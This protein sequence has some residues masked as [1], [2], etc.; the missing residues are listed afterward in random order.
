MDTHLFKVYGKYMYLFLEIFL[1]IHF[2]WIF[3]AFS[4]KLSSS[5]LIFVIIMFSKNVIF[6]ILAAILQSPFCKG[7]NE[8]NPH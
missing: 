4:I 8:Q 7:E 1:S 3:E 2:K 6:K 5:T